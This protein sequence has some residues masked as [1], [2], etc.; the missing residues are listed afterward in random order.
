MS[1]VALA[2][3]TKQAGD[4]LRRIPDA[5]INAS[6]DEY[7]HALEKS[8]QEIAAKGLTSKRIPVDV[9]RL[10]N[11]VCANGRTIDGKGR[12]A[13]VAQLSPSVLHLRAP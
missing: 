13:Y 8:E 9:D 10:F 11:W 1:A 2:W 4:Q 5:C 6:Y 7:V 3:Y 12:A